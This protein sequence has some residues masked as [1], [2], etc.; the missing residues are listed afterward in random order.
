MT[1]SLAGAT[2]QYSTDNGETWTANEPTITNVGTITV[3]VKATLE[4]YL[5]AENT[6]ALEVTPK[7]VTV[8]ADD[9]HVTVGGLCTGVHGNGDRHDR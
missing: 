9:K 5:P 8:K 2:I 4:G 1:P 3:K 6:Y 7:D